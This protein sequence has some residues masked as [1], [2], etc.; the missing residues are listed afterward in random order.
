MAHSTATRAATSTW[1]I[2]PVHSSIEF[3]VKNMMMT[4]VRGR[5]KE[6]H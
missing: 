6:F 5:F 1:Q 2:D 3:S 4:T